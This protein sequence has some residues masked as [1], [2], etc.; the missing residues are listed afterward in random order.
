MMATERDRRKVVK[1]NSEHEFPF[2]LP[3]IMLEFPFHMIRRK[4][5]AR[6]MIKN[7]HVGKFYFP[8]SS[9]AFEE[10]TLLGSSTRSF[11]NRSDFT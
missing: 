4:Q 3:L 8:S 2:N 5:H 7:C 11:V 1:L 9:F 10:R 6:R